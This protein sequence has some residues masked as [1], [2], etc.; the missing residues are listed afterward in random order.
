MTRRSGREAAVGCGEAAVG[1]GEAAVGCGEAAV[2]ARGLGRDYGGHRAVASLDLEVEAGGFY[3]LLGPNGAGKTT[4]VHML[5][6][7]L[8]PSRGTARIRGVDVREDPVAVRRQVGLVFQETTLD[9][10]LTARENLEFTAALYGLDRGTARERAGEILELFGLRERRDDRVET[11]SGGM[12]RALDIGRGL[13]HRPP[14]LFLDE[15][16]VGLDPVNRRRIWRLLERIRAEREITLFLT[17]HYLEEAEDCDRVGIMDRGELVAEGAPRELK[18]GLRPEVIELEASRDADLRERIEAAV[19]APA[20]RRSFGWEVAVASAKDV[21]PALLGAVEE[22]IDGLRLRRPSLEDVFVQLTG[23]SIGAGGEAR[24][25][26]ER[27]GDA[28]GDG[29]R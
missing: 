23:R 11:F 13:L 27:E 16:T 2:I 26:E 3:A 19:G 20:R 14:V 12:K 15:P 4:T 10:D 1:C 6:T 18:R 21:L 29:G 8:R 25:P 28:R 24:E 7:L 5:T 22:E 17:T 9:T